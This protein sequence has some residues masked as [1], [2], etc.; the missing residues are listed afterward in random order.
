M[1][2]KVK[3][4][5]EQ[6]GI[7]LSKEIIEFPADACNQIIARWDHPLAGYSIR[8]LLKIWQYETG[9]AFRETYE[10]FDEPQ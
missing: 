10:N 9:Q 4:T 6:Q 1:I 5:L 2:D 8:D 3:E 7:D